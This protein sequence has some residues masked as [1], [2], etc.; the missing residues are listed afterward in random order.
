M[1]RNIFSLSG[2]CTK[3]AMWW[4]IASIHLQKTAMT[5]DFDMPTVWANN[6]NDGL[7]RSLT[8]VTNSWSRFVN[9]TLLVG[10]NLDIKLNKVTNVNQFKPIKS[11]LFLSSPSTDDADMGRWH[12]EV[13]SSLTFLT[14][15]SLSRRRF[16]LSSTT[17]LFCSSESEHCSVVSTDWTSSCTSEWQCLAR[18][19]SWSTGM[20]SCRFR[21]RSYRATFFASFLGVD[22][23]L[24]GNSDGT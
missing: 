16:L 18:F 1:V 6:R 5:V 10:T 7:C 21:T 13:S 24:C 22:T 17:M 14:A 9:F 3:N 20:F 11:L 15:S 23:F 8:R 4:L 12:T 19:G 2:Q